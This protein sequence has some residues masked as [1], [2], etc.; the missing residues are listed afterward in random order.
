MKT[1]ILCGGKGTRLRELTEKL[2]KPLIEIGGKPILWHVMKIYANY[3]YKDF[4]L[5]LGYKGEMIEKYFKENPEDWNIEFVHTGEE[6][7][8]G[9]RIKKV[10]S[11]IT[12]DE[13]MATY[14]DGVSL[15][16]L[17]ELLKHHAA[18]NAIAT[19]TCVKPK[20]RFGI[21][22]INDQGLVNEF[23]EK[24]RLPYWV[25]GGFFVFKKEI[26]NYLNE[27]DVLEKDVFEK[28]AADKKIAAYKLEGF[29]ECMDTFKDMQMLD[30]LWNT[31]KAEWKT[32][33]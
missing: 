33:E 4:V 9:G 20:S 12:D 11:Y 32:W 22:E 18:N 26:F 16:N 3:S 7:N 15:I 14:G 23:V 2:P 5:A 6:T 25:N 29:W 1:V 13:F 31:G 21:V 19:I 10:E 8:T 24:P 30:E 17:N 27:T 28:L